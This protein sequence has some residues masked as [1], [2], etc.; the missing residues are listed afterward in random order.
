MFYLFIFYFSMLLTYFFLLYGF[1]FAVIFTQFCFI[2]F[3]IFVIKFDLTLFFFNIYDCDLAFFNDYSY[4]TR[5]G[6]FYT[7]N[8]HSYSKNI[9][10]E[11]NLDN[12]IEGDG[13]TKEYDEDVIVY[14]ILIATLVILHAF[15]LD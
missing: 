11:V 6:H 4:S 3:F 14:T 10:L 15:F 9:K 13:K 8:T 7:K 1:R 12:L 2:L 5:T